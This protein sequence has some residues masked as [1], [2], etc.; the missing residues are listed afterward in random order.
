VVKNTGCSSKGSEF[1][2]QHPYSGSQPS[3]TPVPGDLMS[4][5]GLFGYQGHK[6]Y[7]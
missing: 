4:S 3:V 6:W 7:E 5:S 2:S 1:D